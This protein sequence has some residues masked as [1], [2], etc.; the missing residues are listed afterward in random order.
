M[1]FLFHLLQHS[2]DG[3]R[4]LEDVIARVIFQLREL[5]HTAFWDPENDHRKVP[6]LCHGEGEFNVVVEGFTPGLVDFIAHARAELGAR[7]ICLAT[8]EPT[9]KGFNH[10]LQKEMVERQAIFPEAMKH[11][12]GILH[13]V[14]G[15]RVTRWYGRWAPAAQAELGYAPAMVRPETQAEP[16]WDFGFFGSLSPRREAL[17]HRLSSFC[18]KKIRIVN[19]FKTAEQ[20]DLAMQQAKVILQVRKFDEMG[21]VSSSRCCTA[22]SIGRPVIAEPHD[23]ELSK[24]W[25]S[26]VKFTPSESAFFLTAKMA[27]AQWRQLHREQF[28]KFKQTLTPQFCVGEPLAR[29]GITEGNRKAA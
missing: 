1:K 9:D 15:E 19:D 28:A 10:G 18:G 16:A 7:F 4:S 27:A 20:R 26:I 12:E 11:F 8:E 21:L 25:D 6:L 2:A 5:G 23:I 22:L 3:K 29:I 17:L 13:L 14:P 24:P